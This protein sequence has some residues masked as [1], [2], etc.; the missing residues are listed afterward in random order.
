L[1]DLIPAAAKSFQKDE[2]ATGHALLLA[3]L[4]RRNKRG[5]FPC[6]ADVWLEGKQKKRLVNVAEF[7]HYIDSNIVLEL[8]E[9]PFS[10][11][12]DTLH[13]KRALASTAPSVAASTRSCFPT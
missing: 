6:F 10:R 12:D 2:I 13:P 3:R 7:S 9:A 8:S 1:A 11:E 4:S 5:V